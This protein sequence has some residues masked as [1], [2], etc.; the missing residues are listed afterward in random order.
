MSTSVREHT[1]E[2]PAFAVG[3]KVVA[4][5]SMDEGPSSDIPLMRCACKGDLL[6]VREVSFGYRNCITVSHEHIT[7]RPFCVAP[8]EIA[9]AAADGRV[10]P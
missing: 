8:S 5:V 9:K 6:I 7:D 2:S 1:Q 4:L 3:D 10:A